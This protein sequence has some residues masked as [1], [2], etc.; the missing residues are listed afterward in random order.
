M[1]QS[2]ERVESNDIELSRMELLSRKF[3]ASPM[4]ALLQG[5]ARRVSLSLCVF[6]HVEVSRY[7]FR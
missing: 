4:C 2:P 6:G 7:G 5:E 3:L 1:A